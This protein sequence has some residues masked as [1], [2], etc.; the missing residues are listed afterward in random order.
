MLNVI[1]Q[2]YVRRDPEIA[3]ILFAFKLC[4]L[5]MFHPLPHPFP[6]R[7]GR[8]SHTPLGPD[9]ESP[10]SSAVIKMWGFAGS[11][12]STTPGCRDK[13]K[14]QDKLP[15]TKTTSVLVQDLTE[16]KGG[17]GGSPGNGGSCS[18]CSK[19]L[20]QRAHAD[21]S[22]KEADREDEGQELEELKNH[23]ESLRAQL[24]SAEEREGGRE[25]KRERERKHRPVDSLNDL[26]GTRCVAP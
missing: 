13:N 4:M 9:L 5:Q 25:R 23:V 24:R 10:Y 7:A 15:P 22:S 8:T 3:T 12:D 6:E 11:G 19:L 20:Q 21:I 2:D 18:C 1:M 17:S 26:A 16:S 14:V